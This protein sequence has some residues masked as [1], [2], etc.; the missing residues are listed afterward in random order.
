MSKTAIITG[1]AVGIGEEIVKKFLAN[2]YKV[3]ATYNHTKPKISQEN[4]EYKHVDITDRMSCESFIKYINREKFIPS[5]FVNNA[6]IAKDKMFHKM[7]YEDWEHVLNV[8]LISLFHL[9]QPIFSMMRDENYGRIINISSV[10][11]NKGQLG[12][13]NYCAA[14]AGIQG[15]TRALALEGARFGITVNT[16]SPGYTDTNM[17]NGIR[18][19][20]L[21][22]IIDKIPMKRLGLPSEIADS[23]LYLAS[24]AAQYITGTNL[25]INGGLYFS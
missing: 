12:Q 8:N 13:V 17:M 22:D 2:D 25:E 3:I 18:E 14:K 7:S 11:A 23:V 15:F 24:D 4:L 6:G 10:N 20:I 16:V 5:V 21:N 1:G 9:T 19:E